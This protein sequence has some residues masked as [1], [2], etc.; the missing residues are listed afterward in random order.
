MVRALLT[1]A[2]G[3]VAE[4]A[5]VSPTTAKLGVSTFMHIDIAR[6]ARQRRTDGSRFADRLRRT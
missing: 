2:G 1:A 3:T 6:Q 5:D 4:R